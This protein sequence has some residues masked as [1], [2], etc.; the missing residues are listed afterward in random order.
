MMSMV[1]VVPVVSVVAVMPVVS[2]VA[3]WRMSVVAMVP[4]VP[5]RDVDVRSMPMMEMPFHRCLQRCAALA[6]PRER[7]RWMV[8][9]VRLVPRGLLHIILM[10][11]LPGSDPIP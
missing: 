9:V 1:A 11:R 8:S 4:V 3:M 7:A 6:V 5:V 10:L 2:V